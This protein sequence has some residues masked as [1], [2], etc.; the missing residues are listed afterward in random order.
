MGR[1]QIGAQGQ[2]GGDTAALQTQIYEL[3]TLVDRPFAQP[4]IQSVRGVGYRLVEAA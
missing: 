1:G 4:M 3:R 2:G